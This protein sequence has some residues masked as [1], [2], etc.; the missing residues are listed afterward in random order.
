MDHD[1]Q[2]FRILHELLWPSPGS[3][4]TAPV[5]IEN[6]VPSA[7]APHAPAGNLHPSNTATS[8]GPATAPLDVLHQPPDD[9]E[10]LATHTILD[11]AFRAAQRQELKAATTDLQCAPIGLLPSLLPCESSRL[12]IRP[13]YVSFLQIMEDRDRRRSDQYMSLHQLD[14]IDAQ[15]LSEAPPMISWHVV[16]TGQPGIGSV[17]ML[18][19]DTIRSPNLTVLI[20]QIVSLILYSGTSF[21]LWPAN[22][23]SASRVPELLFLRQDWR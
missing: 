6:W 5:I 4:Y 1:L 2:R 11:L 12:L 19:S 21:T 20:R 3:P 22:Y 13:A 15:A 7:A 16:L 17:S 9:D 10:A 18:W 14:H 8:M 23:L